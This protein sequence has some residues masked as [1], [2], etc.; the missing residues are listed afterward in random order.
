MPPGLRPSTPPA[1][2][3]Q[4]VIFDFG[5]VLCAFDNRRIAAALAPVCRRTPEE[6]AGLIANS[7]LPRAYESGT[8][9]SGAFLAGISDL[10]GCA[11]EEGFFVRAFTEIFTPIE[12]TWRLVRELK[13][14]LRLGLL[15][16]TNPWH[17][18]YGIRT[19]AIFPLF[20]TVT[21]SYEVGALKPDRRIFEDAL[22]KLAL[23]PEA[24]AFVDDIPAFVEGARGLG[25]HGIPFTGPEALRVAL[26][27]LGL[28][29]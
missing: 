28:D 19:T 21:L 17:F 2:P 12:G 5:N 1:S 29:V 11:F 20:D 22:A 26:R 13:G 9:T 7:E 25:M 24:C 16:N 3:I 23:P 10:C 4:A 15:S 14:R 27:N 8:L 6:L 18:E